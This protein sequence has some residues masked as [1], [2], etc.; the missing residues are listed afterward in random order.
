MSRRRLNTRFS[1]MADV[2]RLRW[3]LA[4]VSPEHHLEL[5]DQFPETRLVWKAM[6]TPPERLTWQVLQTLIGDCNKATAY[7][8]LAALRDAGC[9]G[10]CAT[11]GDREA[12]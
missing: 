7:R 4:H 9:I 2:I 12:A 11:A 3:L 8:W 10:T 5:F 6:N 1:Y